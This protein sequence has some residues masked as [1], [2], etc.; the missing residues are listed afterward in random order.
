MK[1]PPGS[2]MVKRARTLRRDMTDAEALV[3]RRLRASQLGVKFRRQ[4]WL[5]GF[6][7]DFASVEA[8]L[9]IEVDGGQHDLDREK[10][11][12]RAA[13]MAALGYRTLRF[14]NHEVLQNIDGVLQ[15]IS[16]AIPSPSHPAAPGGPLPLPRMGE[17]R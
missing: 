10:D 1:H 13:A 4:M 14:W 3:W 7:A 17:G 6:V 2:G 11:A 5:G 15:V 16:A 8:K 9:V 12:R